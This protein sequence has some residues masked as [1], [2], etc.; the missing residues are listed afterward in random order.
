MKRLSLADR[1]RQK[2]KTRVSKLERARKPLKEQP[3]V[4][5]DASELEYEEKKT[6]KK[7]GYTRRRRNED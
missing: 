3:E 6:R 5:E 7:R 4:I 2:N 1:Q